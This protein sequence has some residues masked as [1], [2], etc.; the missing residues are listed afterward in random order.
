MNKGYKVLLALSLGLNILMFQNYFQSVLHK[1][2]LINKSFIED[3]GIQAGSTEL[4]FNESKLDEY[5]KYKS[6]ENDIIFLGDSITQRGSW[7]EYFPGLFVRNR[8]IDGDGTENILHR[9]DPVVNGCPSK[10]FLLI[11]I[12]DLAAQFDNEKILAN[13]EKIILTIQEKTPKTKIYAGS[14]LPVN[15]YKLKDILERETNTTIPITNQ[16][17][18]ALNTRLQTLCEK[19]R[20]IYIDYYTHVIEAGELKPELTKDGL[21]LNSDGYIVLSTV[22][23]PYLTEK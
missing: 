20:V 11:G 10:I 9:L 4:G 17:I 3:K 23:Q 18:Q 22:L 16:N 19:N 1:E 8:G 14:I 2:S 13:Y 5:K 15:S 6:T 12:N 7:S 21:H